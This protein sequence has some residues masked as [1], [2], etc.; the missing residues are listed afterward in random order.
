[1]TTVDEH[2]LVEELV[3]DGFA[4]AA[5]TKFLCHGD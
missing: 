4:G 3:A 2:W 1:M 5:A